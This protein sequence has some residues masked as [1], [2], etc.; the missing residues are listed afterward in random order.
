MSI[1]FLV[2]IYSNNLSVWSII[3]LYGNIKLIELENENFSWKQLFKDESSFFIVCLQPFEFDPSEKS[4]HKFM[5]QT[6]IAPEGEFNQDTLV[7]TNIWFLLRWQI[8][9]N[10][11]FVSRY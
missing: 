6:M 11:T 8:Y 4:K 9:L 10:I 1:F 2:V 5:V 7:S 3:S